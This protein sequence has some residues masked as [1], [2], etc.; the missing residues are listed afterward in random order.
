MTELTLTLP[1]LQRVLQ[2]MAMSFLHSINGRDNFLDA[3]GINMKLGL[4][5]DLFVSFL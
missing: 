1:P 2:R 3:E 5:L 4:F